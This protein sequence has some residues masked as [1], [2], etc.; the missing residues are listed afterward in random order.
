MNAPGILLLW[1]AMWTSPKLCWISGTATATPSTAR[2]GH[3]WVWHFRP[4]IRTNSGGLGCKCVVFPVTC[5]IQISKISMLNRSIQRHSYPL[6]PLSV[7]ITATKATKAT[8]ALKATKSM[9]LTYAYICLHHPIWIS[10]SFFSVSVD[11]SNELFQ[12]FEVSISSEFGNREFHTSHWA[13]IGLTLDSMEFSYRHQNPWTMRCQCVA[14]ALR[15]GHNV[16]TT[17]SGAA[18]RSCR[19]CASTA[20][21]RPRPTPR[22]A[23]PAPSKTTRRRD[24]EVTRRNWSNFDRFEID[25]FW[26]FNDDG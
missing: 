15:R 9:K 13:H 10:S 8:K 14:N 6:Y 5:C 18:S 26:G 4:V 11:L 17:R 23:A 22:A 25:N 1:W 7:R 16:R 21:R 2:A 20:P 3:L 12:H 24:T 19:C